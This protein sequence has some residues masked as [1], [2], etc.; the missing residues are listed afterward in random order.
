MANQVQPIIYQIYV[1]EVLF[2][3]MPMDVEFNFSWGQHDIFLARF[4]YYRGLNLTTLATWADNS[5]IRVIWGYNGSTQTWYG[6]VNHHTID[7]NSDSGSKDMQITYTCIGTSKPMNSDVTKSWGQVSGT[8]MAKTI[9]AKY[10]FRSV[11]TTSSWVLPSE[12]QANESDFQFLNRISDKIGYRF[13]VSGGTLYFIDPSV[14]IQSSTSQAVPSFYMDKNFTYKDTI[15]N[16]T[17]MKGDNLPGSV[18]S[19]RSMY[20]LDAQTGQAFQV[21]ANVSSTSNSTTVTPTIQQINV[22]WPVSDQT[23]ATNLVNAWQGR[24]QFWQTATAELYGDTLLYP[25]KLV[26]ITGAQM[27]TESTG[28]WLVSAADHVL[29]SSG[30]GIPNYDRYVA[31]VTLIKNTAE[32]TLSLKQI[33]PVSPE[34]VGCTL[35][36]NLWTASSQN[37]V[38]ENTGYSGQAL[39]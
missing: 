7:A 33:T 31:H 36:S 6:Y 25:G 34:F 22:E 27:P 10:G 15:R 35:S 13:W 4:E 12:T 9:A 1:N 28:N 18:Q 38:Y 32:Q 19:V 26:T 17:M 5:P 20:G 3:Y 24:S 30:S 21:T 8:Y 14:A 11:L 2:N 29:R 37:V 39:S 23:T 16:F